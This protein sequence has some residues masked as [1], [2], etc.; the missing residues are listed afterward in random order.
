[1]KIKNI[2]LIFF[3]IKII[4]FLIIAILLLTE[5]SE[6]AN[7]LT[8]N[9]LLGLIVFLFVLLLLSIRNLNEN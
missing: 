9:Q 8:N 5:F 1:M 6:L 3:Y 7:V 4:I 2:G